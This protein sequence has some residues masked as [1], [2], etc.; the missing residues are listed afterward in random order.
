MEI[1][2]IRNATLVVNYA[3]KT[4]LIDPFFADK[5]AMPP[6]PNTPNQDK[7]NPMVSLPVPIK[8]IIEADAVIVTHL[9]PD[10]YD[11]AAIK[12]L[13]KEISIYAQNENDAAAIRQDGFVHAQSLGETITVGDIKITKTG[14]QHGRGEITKMTGQ[15]SGVVFSHPD[16]KT[17]YI[18][19]DTIW[20]EDVKEALQKHN[21]E[22]I[23]VNGGAAQFL[24]GGTITMDKEDIE[25]LHHAASESIIVVSHMETLNHCL[26]TRRDLRE[27]LSAKDWSGKALVPEDGETIK[28]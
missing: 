3:G 6:F 9:H 17:L 4:F 26:L 24:E 21:P 14:G 22:V 15:V 19:G 25:Q 5:G 23:V 8:E 13:P 20:C 1:R 27:F 7:R 18:A 10:H 16:E 11:D 2:L 12:D 28:F